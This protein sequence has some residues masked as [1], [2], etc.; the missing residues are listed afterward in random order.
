M[1]KATAWGREPQYLIRDRD[2]VYGADVGSK[3]ASAGIQ[4]ELLKLGYQVSATTIRGVLRHHRMQPAPRRDGLSWAQ[5]LRAP[6]P[7]RS[8]L[9]TS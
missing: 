9:A 3:L 5:F 8:W 6:T 2:N 7:A 1:I 4:G